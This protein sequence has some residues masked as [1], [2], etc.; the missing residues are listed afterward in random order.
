MNDKP[1]PKI[2]SFWM[3]SFAYLFRLFIPSG[4]TLTDFSQMYYLFGVRRIHKT[5][6]MKQWIPWIQC[7]GSGFTLKLIEPFHIAP[8]KTKKQNTQFTL[9]LFCTTY[10]Y[11][12]SYHYS[13]KS[14][15]LFELKYGAGLC[16]TVVGSVQ[17]S[18]IV[19]IME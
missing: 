16:F 15:T 11:N 13:T 19:H 1:F 2:R 4:S 5:C 6:R 10:Y 7:V 14:H 17:C 9:W 8:K 3:L 18:A 12:Y